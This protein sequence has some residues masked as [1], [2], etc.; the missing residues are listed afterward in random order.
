M[1]KFRGIEISIISQ[2]DICK[3]PEFCFRQT[4]PQ[5]DP[6]REIT[7]S[8]LSNAAASCFVPVYPGSHSESPLG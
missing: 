6:F 3:L 7:S 4:T 8:P 1:V 5:P 2:F